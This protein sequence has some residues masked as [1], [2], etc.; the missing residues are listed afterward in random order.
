M[1]ITAVT[2]VKNEGPF[3]L[4]WIAYNRLIGVTD[5]LF[6]SNDCTDGT[7]E[8][9][10]ALAAR[11]LLTHLPNPAQ[12]RNYQMEALK[13]AAHQPLVQEADWV[14]IA[15]VDEFLNI[16][17]G[18]HT[19]P[20]LITACGNP[21][22]ISVSFQ[23]FANNG[24]EAFVDEPV[25]AQFS[26]SHNPDIWCAE[27]AIEVKTLVRQDFPLKYY[28]AHRP[29]F[30]KGLPPRRFPH[31]CDGSGRDV[32]PKFLVADN[33]RRIRKFPAKG[34]RDLAT[35]NHY[36]LRSL[37][38]YLV[39]NDRGDV[40][41]EHRAFD[42]SYWRERNDPSYEDRSIQRYLP[43]LQQALKALKSDVEIATLH[44]ICLQ[45]HRDKRDQLLAQPAYQKMRR[46]LLATPTLPP[47]EEALL[48]D[49]GLLPALGY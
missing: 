13:D 49:L 29:F 19:I 3:L 20:A 30:K 31:W 33:P 38:S 14:W 6:Y 5:F 21:G 16:H 44:E 26:R 42:D 2:C 1:R 32:P 37:D 9:L 25:I 43:G 48:T 10:D 17:T 27:T 46:Q 11:G 39:K 12:G 18:D 4:E 47:Q 40:N 23:F 28:G 22:A 36:A 8:L 45:R 7:A 24:I 15:D 41:R 35:L 34:S